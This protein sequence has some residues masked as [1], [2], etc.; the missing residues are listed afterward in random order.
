MS[1]QNWSVLF[2]K[3]RQSRSQSPRY[4]DS[5][6]SGEVLSK[7]LGPIKMFST[8]LAS[9][10]YHSWNITNIPCCRMFLNFSSKGTPISVLS[11][12]EEKWMPFLFVLLDGCW[13]HLGFLEHCSDLVS[14][15]RPNGKVFS[16]GLNVPLCRHFSAIYSS[17]CH[18]TSTENVFFCVMWF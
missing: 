13:P 17:N 15:W 12:F 8:L 7:K 5:R 18:L 10:W 16:Q 11:F 3:K 14:Q 2:L 4:P 1:E 9:L 6:L